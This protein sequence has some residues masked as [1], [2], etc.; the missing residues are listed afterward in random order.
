MKIPTDEEAK[1]YILAL[2]AKL[3]SILKTRWFLYGVILVCLLA[4]VP[5]YVYIYKALSGFYNPTEWAI[6]AV[7]TNWTIGF[8]AFWL[9]TG[10]CTGLLLKKWKVP[11]YLR[12]MIVAIIMF[13]FAYIFMLLGFGGSRW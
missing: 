2:K 6:R 3:A 9:G 7:L 5:S 13:L 11:S 1:R 8:A 10:A 4:V 12:P